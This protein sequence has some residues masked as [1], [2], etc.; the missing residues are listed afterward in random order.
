MEDVTGV[1]VAPLDLTFLDPGVSPLEEAPGQWRFRWERGG[2]P[3]EGGD[4]EALRRAEIVLTPMRI[5]ESLSPGRFEALLDS[6]PPPRAA[7]R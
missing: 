3:A 7:S 5:G 2:E 4:V 1:V 6:I